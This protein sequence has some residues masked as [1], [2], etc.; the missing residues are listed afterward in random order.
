M[1]VVDGAAECLTPGCSWRTA[2][3]NAQ[4]TAAQHAV[5]LEHHVSVTMGYAVESRAAR[6]PIPLPEGV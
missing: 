4:G 3:R 1:W 6:R 2:G 5:K